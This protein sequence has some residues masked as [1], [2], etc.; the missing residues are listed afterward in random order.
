MQKLALGVPETLKHEKRE[1]EWEE[2]KKKRDLCN[3]KNGVFW[4]V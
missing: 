4:D 2:R 1:E 3:L